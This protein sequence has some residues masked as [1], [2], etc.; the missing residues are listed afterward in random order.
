ML[1]LYRSGRQAD[2][3]EAYGRLYGLL[4]DEL[5]VEPSPPVRELHQRMLTG[6]PALD[7]PDVSVPRQLPPG[8][9]D[10]TGRAQV[11]DQ[12][13]A[14]LPSATGGASTVVIS[15]IAGTAGVGKTAVALHWAHRIKDR[16]PD[17]QLYVDL[18]GFDAS[19]QTVQPDEAVRGFLEALGIPRQRIPADLRAQI[20]LYRSLMAGRRT[21]V[22]LDNARDA[23]QVRPLLAGAAG[24]LVMVTSR[25]QLSGLVAANGAQ[26]LPLDVLSAE[27][28]RQLLTRRL[29]AARVSAEPQAVEEIIAGCARLPLALAMVAARAATRPHMPLATLAAQLHAAGRGLD[30]F[31]DIDPRSDLRAV[32]SWSY[33][34]LPPDTGRLFRLLSLHPGPDLAAPAAASLAGLAAERLRPI[35]DE[36]TRGHLLIEPTPGRYTFHDML[37]VDATELTDTHDTEPDRRAALHRLLD[38]YLHTAHSAAALVGADRDPIALRPPQPGAVI[39]QLTGRKQAIAWFTAERRALLAAIDHAASA[40]FHTHAVQLAR[41]VLDFLDHQGHW[42]DMIATQHAA[43]NAAQRLADRPEQARAHRALGYAY[44][45]LGVY[46]DAHSHLQRALELDRTLG[47]DL[48]KAHTH[49]IVALTLERQ[50]HY[51][52]A[53]DHARQALDLYRATGHQPGQART[54]NMISSYHGRLGVDPPARAEGGNALAVSHPLGHPTA[55][56]TDVAGWGGDHSG[57]RSAGDHQQTASYHQHA[58]NLV[59]EI[60]HRHQDTDLR[61]NPAGNGSSVAGSAEPA[62]PAGC[63]LPACGGC[64]HPSAWAAAQ[65]VAPNPGGEDETQ[66]SRMLQAWMLQA[67]VEPPDR[68]NP[69]G[70]ELAEI[71]RLRAEVQDLRAANEILKAATIFFARELDPPYR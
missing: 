19:G 61:P 17:G 26:L 49:Q 22:V 52:P 40:G 10:F 66:R 27:D 6:D 41:A 68:R 35:L 13:D 46:H 14:L 30:P 48:G 42:H 59:R 33:H 38:H 5:G 63:P 64:R 70:E 9:G 21:L 4:R 71:K 54:L 67:Q 53:L 43:L 36:L 60:A 7:A 29:G 15:A 31:T 32:L 2:A 55:D 24:S 44:S 69:S 65:P 16:F 47:D 56:V 37:R 1:A 51:L 3:L 23:E 62:E 25:S 11:L 18:R 34:A 20:G 8:V 12:L 28:A 58:L 45:G 39:P 50:D 57:P